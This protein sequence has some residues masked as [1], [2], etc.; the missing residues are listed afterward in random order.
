MTPISHQP[1]NIASQRTV[2]RDHRRRQAKERLRVGPEWRGT[3]DYVFST[4]WGEPIH[5]NTVSSL[6]TTLIKTHNDQ[7]GEPLPQFRRCPVSEGLEPP[8]F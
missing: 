3:D 2:L 4:G 7:Q 5:P 1:T 8:T 6:M